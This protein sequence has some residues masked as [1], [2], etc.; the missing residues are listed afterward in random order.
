[1]TTTLDTTTT[2]KLVHEVI[3]DL[4]QYISRDVQV[5]GGDIV[6]SFVNVVRM[7]HR[8]EIDELPDSLREVV[9]TAQGKPTN[10]YDFYDLRSKMLKMAGI[11]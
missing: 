8:M 2:K 7:D 1:M 5:S 6:S 4:Q 11:M 9:T 10:M 3:G